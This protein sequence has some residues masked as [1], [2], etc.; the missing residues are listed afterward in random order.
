MLARFQNFILP[1]QDPKLRYFTMRRPVM[2]PLPHSPLDQKI[3]WIAT[4]L[5]SEIITQYSRYDSDSTSDLW[6]CIRRC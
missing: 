4:K 1:N 6:S 2:I 5:F 3:E